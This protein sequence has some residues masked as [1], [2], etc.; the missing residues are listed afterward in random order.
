MSFPRSF[1][2]PLRADSV[3]ML[4]SLAIA[5]KAPAMATPMARQTSLSATMPAR[6]EAAGTGRAYLYS[7]VDGSPLHVFEAEADGDGLGSESIFIPG[8]TAA[9]SIRS[10]GRLRKMPSA[11]MR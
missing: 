10:W 6:G 3:G 1:R 9:Y 4:P 5:A 2:W 8:R 7:G 11:S